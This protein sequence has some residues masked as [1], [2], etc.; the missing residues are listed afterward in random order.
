MVGRK[1]GAEPIQIFLNRK[2]KEGKRRNEDLQKERG[3][4]DSKTG[5]GGTITVIYE[6]MGASRWWVRKEK[7]SVLVR[8]RGS[9]KEGS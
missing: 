4:G 3:G 8:E 6:K 1:E 5:G 7:T 9:K 2:R